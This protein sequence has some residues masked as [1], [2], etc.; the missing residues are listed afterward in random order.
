[1]GEGWITAEYSLLPRATHDRTTREAAAGKIGGRTHE[2]QRLI[3]RCLRMAVDLRAIGERTITLDCDVLQADGGTRTAAITGAW[4]A[5]HD[6]ISWL[7]AK[8]LIATMPKI[9]QIA[10]VS[11]GIYRGD[12]LL[13]LSYEEDR[14]AG[15]DANIVML[16]TGKFIEVQFTSE[17]RDF[18]KAELDQLLDLARSGIRQLWQLQRDVIAQP[19]EMVAVAA[20]GDRA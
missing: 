14:E 16:G 4:I 6:A 17:G 12:P 10:A 18:D 15:V 5:L 1:P 9:E 8:R 13:D 11:V 3:G 2:I 19:L 20:I 7:K